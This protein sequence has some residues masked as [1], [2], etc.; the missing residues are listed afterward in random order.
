MK[1]AYIILAHN[2]PEQLLRLVDQLN[3]DKTSF[4]IHI[5]K[6]SDRKI[7]KQISAELMDFPNVFFLKRY[8]SKWGSFGIVK[9]TLKVINSIVETGICFDY[10]ILLSGQDYLIKS[11][12]YIKMFL[13]EN[14]GKEFIEYFSLPDKRWGEHGGLK[15]IDSWHFSWRN[16]YFDIPEKQKFQSYIASLLYSLVILLLPKKRKLIEG[17]AIYGG[18]QFWCL[19]GECIKW[20]N[21]FVQQNPKF[22]KRFHYTFCPDEIFFQTI[23]LNSHFKD[24][25]VNN[26][27][28]Y[29]DW[30][31]VNSCHPMILDKNDVEKIRQSEK[32]FARKFDPTK[33][34]DILDMIDQMILSE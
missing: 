23:I 9:A 33:D 29:I 15:R 27:L 32:L 16:K 17:Y 5:D 14:Q 12:T 20:I 8:N 11:N 13:Q 25:V 18:S 34:S 2:Y 30:G 3:T 22:V 7:F 24:K 10:I 1:V 26:N 6:S 28:K 31:N 21:I 19:T 4:F